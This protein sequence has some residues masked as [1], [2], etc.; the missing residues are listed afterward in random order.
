MLTGAPFCTTALNFWYLPRTR[1]R[2]RWTHDGLTRSGPPCLFHGLTHR[3][4]YSK[5]CCCFC[6]FLA[7]SREISLE[8]FG[9]DLVWDW[10]PQIKGQ[11]L[12]LSTHEKYSSEIQ[13]SGM[14]TGFPLLSVPTVNCWWLSQARIELVCRYMFLRGKQCWRTLSKCIW[15]R[16]IQN[17]FILSFLHSVRDK[18]EASH[19]CRLRCAVLDS[20]ALALTCCLLCLCAKQHGHIAICRDPPRRTP[21]SASGRP[22]V[23]KSWTNK[24]C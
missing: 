11:S 24:L 5:I 22:D 19:V 17:A 15:I 13:Y 8:S 9:S 20:R 16:A 4:W 10:A 7:V 3:L 21:A 12:H 23:L 1:D 6:W 2:A 18:P 14:S